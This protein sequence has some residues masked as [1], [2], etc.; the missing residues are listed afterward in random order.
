MSERSVALRIQLD[1]H[2]D[3]AIAHQLRRRGVDA[4]TA[5][6]AG[7]LATPDP[8]IPDH[9]RDAG[10]VVVTY[11]ADYLRLHRIGR[12]HAGIIYGTPRMRDV[13]QIVGM[14]HLFSEI[15]EPESFMNRLEYL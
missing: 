6:E 3:N 2:L 7:L 10:R 11:D 15:E 13:G 8:V 9:A 1:E 5:A 14:V 12:P 4:I